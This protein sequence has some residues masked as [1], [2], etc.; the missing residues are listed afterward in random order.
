MQ[1]WKLPYM[2][3]FIQK[4]PESFA[5]LFPRT[6]KLFGRKVCKFLNPIQD[7]REGGGKKIPYQFFPYNFYKRKN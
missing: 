2:F 1:I 7:P 5:F 4:Y 3:V 6:F